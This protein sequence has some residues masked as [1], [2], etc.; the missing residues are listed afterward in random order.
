M[1]ISYKI[2]PF[3]NIKMNWVTEITQVKKEKFFIDEQRIGPY[4]LWHHQH[5]FEEKNNYVLMKDV[6]TYVPPFG[7]L[8]VLANRLFIEDRLTEI[9]DYRFYAMQNFFNN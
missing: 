5:F 3:F 1:I 2:I 7:L 8:G 6:V 9:F 4:K